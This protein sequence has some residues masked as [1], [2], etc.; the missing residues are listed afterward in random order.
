M[1]SRKRDLIYVQYINIYIVFHKC[2]V[3]SRAVVACAVA[4]SL[5]LASVF[6]L[7]IELEQIMFYIIYFVI[8][9]P[10]K[11]YLYYRSAYSRRWLT[12]FVKQKTCPSLF[13]HRSR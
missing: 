11:K 8:W 10:P 2:R 5:A 6:R 9:S 7:I 1:I 3:C 12:C 4:L 13:D